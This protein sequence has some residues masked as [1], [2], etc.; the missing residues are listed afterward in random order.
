MSHKTF[1]DW[2][3]LSESY[4]RQLGDLRG[5]WGGEYELPDE[6]FYLFGMG[7]RRK[8][9][10]REGTLRDALSGAVLRGWEVKAETI[11]PPAYAVVLETVQGER[12]VIHEDE[13]AVWLVEDGNQTA[14]SAMS[15]ASAM[16]LPALRGAGAEFLCLPAPVVSGWGDDG[17][18]TARDRK[19]RPDPR[20]GVGVR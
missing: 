16:H 5:D 9:L 14:L 17:D 13:E 11:I 2:M 18:G 10:Y 15:A 20:L 7:A 6:R 1:L 8:L 19:P 3:S 12:I 4:R